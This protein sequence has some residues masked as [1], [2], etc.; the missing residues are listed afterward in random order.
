VR[1]FVAQTR[2]AELVRRLWRLGFG[3]CTLRGELPPRR[4]PW[5]Y[6][7]GA[8]SDWTAGRPFDSAQ[9]L[10][11]VESIY[12]AIDRPEW[13]VLPDLVARGTDSLAFSLSWLHRLRGLAPLYLAVQDGM[14][15]SDVA[16][17]FG[18]I[19]GIFVG[20]TL[21][22]KVRTGEA[23]AQLAHANDRRCHIGRCGSVRRVR[24]AQRI[25]ADSID[26]ALPLWSDANLDRFLN[27]LEPTKQHELFAEAA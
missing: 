18:G 6:D 2:S 16:P 17:L 23:W 21:R 7:N 20:G 5:F 14:E 15:L 19:A 26:S 22:W 24:W 11:D 1:V 12:L 9:F 3:E 25:G 4:H 13:I 8:Y 27:A 10:A